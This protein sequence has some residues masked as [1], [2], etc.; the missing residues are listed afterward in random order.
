MRAVGARRLGLSEACQ[1]EAL[2]ILLSPLWLMILWRLSDSDPPVTY[3]EF[4][5][6]PDRFTDLITMVGA[7]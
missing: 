7:K 2:R 5:L 1:H 4:T 3:K 6:Q